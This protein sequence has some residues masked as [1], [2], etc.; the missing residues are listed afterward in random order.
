M[1]GT[2]RSTA[3]RAKLAEKI[4]CNARRA[5]ILLRALREKLLLNALGAELHLRLLCALCQKLE[6]GLAL[7]LR[8][9]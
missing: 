8:V 5:M 3:E 6:L 7:L 1:R 4:R 2:A 9:A